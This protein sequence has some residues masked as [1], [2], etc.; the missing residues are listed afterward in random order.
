MHL[1]LNLIGCIQHVFRSSPHVIVGPCVPRLR[2]SSIRCLILVQVL[3]LAT[4]LG[5]LSQ[6][7]VEESKSVVSLQVVLV[8]ELLAILIPSYSITYK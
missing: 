4:D 1:N 6:R 8:R 2:L 5:V 7:I 3:G